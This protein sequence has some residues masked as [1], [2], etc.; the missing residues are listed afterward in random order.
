MNK[1]DF[2]HTGAVCP[3]NC[4]FC[5]QRGG[6]YIDLTS[7]VSEINDTRPPCNLYFGEGDAAGSPHVI[8]AL[9]TASIWGLRR[10]KLKTTGTPLLQNDRLME[11][12]HAG[13]LLYEIDILGPDAKTH[14]DIA[15]RSGAYSDACRAIRS[16]KQVRPRGFQINEL[17]LFLSVPVFGGNI[18]H[19]S[20]ITKE[21][22]KYRPD[23]VV[24]KY[25]GNADYRD[26]ISAIGACIPKLLDAGIWPVLSGFPFC[27]VGGLEYHCQEIYDRQVVPAI[28]ESCGKCVFSRVCCGME[29]ELGRTYLE[30]V[31]EHKY[32]DEIN[33][34]ADMETILLSGK[35]SIR[36]PGHRVDESTIS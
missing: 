32:A 22:I 12:V 17:F 15:G 13:I 9:K 30:P 16:I 34:I 6:K 35:H 31:L 10:V 1:Y 23:R 19:V 25:A 24:Y 29:E 11:L 14:D 21:I 18:E 7:I 20:A 2:I 28:G 8:K 27:V 26:S 3:N 4:E 33:K 36:A 5:S